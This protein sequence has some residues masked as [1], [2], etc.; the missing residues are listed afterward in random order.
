MS[1]AV[2]AMQQVAG[3][4]RIISD[5][6]D[7][8]DILALNAAIEAARAGE[9]GKGFSVVAGE[10]RKL[11]GNSQDS[12]REVERRIKETVTTFESIN[13]LFQQI[14]P[15][16]NKSTVWVREINQS[17]IEQSSGANQIN[18]AII[19]LNQVSQQSAVSSEELASS[20]DVMLQQANHMQAAVAVF[21]V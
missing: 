7:K 17:T 3:V 20:A 15:E 9:Q 14:I 6:A 21:V 11:A 16:I 1:A 5:I 18:T 10:V 12:V 2:I 4:V 8:T 13:Q 19:Q